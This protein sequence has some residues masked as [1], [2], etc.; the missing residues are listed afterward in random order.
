MA[1]IFADVK[2]T[3]EIMGMLGSL[4]RKK[5]TPAAAGR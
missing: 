3:D 4:D 1:R 2:T 5:V